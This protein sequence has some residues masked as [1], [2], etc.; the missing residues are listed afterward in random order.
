MTT[1]IKLLTLKCCSLYISYATSSTLSACKAMQQSSCYL[2]PPGYAGI[3]A[4]LVPAR[5]KKNL[6]PVY[7]YYKIYNCCFIIQI[8]KVAVEHV[9]ATT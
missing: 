1:K 2:V 3:Q 8:G 5:F 9:N 6:S 7:R 4:H